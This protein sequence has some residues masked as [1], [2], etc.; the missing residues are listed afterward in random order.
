V[1]TTNTTTDN[2]DDSLNRFATPNRYDVLATSDKP[3][4][5]AMDDTPTYTPTTD[6]ND[7][8]QPTHHEGAGFPDTTPDDATTVQ[9]G[10]SPSGS[11]PRSPV[12]PITTL[13]FKDELVLKWEFQVDKQTLPTEIK[14]IHCDIMS[15]IYDQ[16]HGELDFL[17]DNHTVMTRMQLSTHV[18]HGKYFCLHRQKD[19]RQSDRTRVE[20]YHRIRTSV[21]LA[22]VKRCN[23]VNT[24]L[25][26]AQV[27]LTDHQWTQDVTDV[28][29]IGWFTRIMNPTVAF[30][31]QVEQEVRGRI[32]GKVGT[33]AGSVPMFRCHSTTVRLPYNSR[34]YVT[35]AVGIQC[36]ATDR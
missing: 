1:G 9:R 21:T 11:R 35:K 12:P 14:Q 31:T 10:S 7:P 4:D 19:N 22:T 15:T 6:T 30:T 20:I 5:V 28:V 26:A 8:S 18:H 23:D 16:F 3:D 34:T 27:W 29:E 13:H 36:R 17:T 2:M 25:R 24:K 32:I 33:S